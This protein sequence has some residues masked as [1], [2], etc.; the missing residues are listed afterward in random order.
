MTG[1]THRWFL[2]S[3]YSHITLVQ[4]GFFTNL[5]LNFRT[6]IH[7]SDSISKED[8]FCKGSSSSWWPI[9]I[10]FAQFRSWLRPDWMSKCL[11]QEY[12]HPLLARF[13]FVSSTSSSLHIGAFHVVRNHGWVGGGPSAQII[14]ISPLLQLKALLSY[15]FNLHCNESCVLDS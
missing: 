13:L 8:Q 5:N 15:N 3:I 1:I 9:H 12:L 4:L 2:E 10:Y 7:S 6:Q 14:T 11:D